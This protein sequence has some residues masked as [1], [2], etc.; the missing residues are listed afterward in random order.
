MVA[1]ARY[2]T[3]TSDRICQGRKTQ[4][5]SFP[6]IVH[7]PRFGPAHL[8]P[9]GWDSYLV[10]RPLLELRSFACSASTILCPLF[11]PKEPRTLYKWL[12]A[13]HG[14]PRLGRW[15]HSSFQHQ[16][17]FPQTREECWVWHKETNFLQLENQPLPIP[18]PGWNSSLLIWTTTNG[19]FHI[20]CPRQALSNSFPPKV[21][22]QLIIHSKMKELR[23]VE[24][25]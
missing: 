2:L 6:T 16:T 12:T 13:P 19:F 18:L 21:F 15:L 14:S 22:P 1:T 11:T 20:Q 5:P 25:W 4:A 7:G 23:S 3:G 10:V 9:P 17:C 8:Q 24:E